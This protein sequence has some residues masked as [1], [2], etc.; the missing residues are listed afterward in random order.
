ML[1]TLIGILFFVSYL[2]AFNYGG[3]GGKSGGGTSGGSSSLARVTSPA[4]SD[5]ANNVPITP[6]LTW[7]ASN[8][9]TYYDVY[10]GT[11][12]TGWSAITTTGTGYTP[13][14]LANS[15]TYYWRVDANYP[16]PNCVV[17]GPVQV[18]KTLKTKRGSID[19][20][21]KH[22]KFNVHEVNNTGL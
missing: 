21:K 9:A 20:G 4:P 19:I 5:N 8:G 18:F 22:R 1:L 17:I 14:S 15:I 13:T 7:S 12:T 3:C 2:S 6:T 11:T 16:D 10:F